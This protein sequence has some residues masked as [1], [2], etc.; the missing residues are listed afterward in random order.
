MSGLGNFIRSCMENMKIAFFLLFSEHGYI[1][2]NIVY[3]SLKFDIL[4][5]HDIM[6]GT[7]SQIFDLGPSHCFISLHMNVCDPF[8]DFIFITY[9]SGE[10][11]MFK[12]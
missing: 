5:I 7:V 12:K 4:I 6:E 1:S 9:I 10:I 8:K 2:L 3:S 11:S